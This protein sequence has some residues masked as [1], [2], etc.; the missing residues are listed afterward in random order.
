MILCLGTACSASMAVPMGSA[1][2][3]H[4]VLPGLSMLK[5]AGVLQP[6]Q[7]PLHLLVVARHVNVDALET[8]WL[9]SRGKHGE[10]N[11][12]LQQLLLPVG[13]LNRWLRQH[14]IIA[15]LHVLSLCLPQVQ[16]NQ[17]QPM[18][19][20]HSESDSRAGNSSCP[21]CCA[22]LVPV[23]REIRPAGKA[24]QHEQLVQAISYQSQLLK[25][26]GLSS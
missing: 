12:L 22:V 14:S 10:H 17:G 26:P 21:H 5:P 3:W 16:C 11:L 6:L 7:K 1:G 4:T 18:P 15:G 8:H 25:A 20:V 9:R 19:P 13:T 23:V 24:Q 2:A